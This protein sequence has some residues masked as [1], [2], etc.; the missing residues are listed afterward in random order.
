MSGSE[1]NARARAWRWILL[2]LIVFWG[3]VAHA[4]MT[5]LG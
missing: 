2:G 3:L 5:R 1:R 4:I